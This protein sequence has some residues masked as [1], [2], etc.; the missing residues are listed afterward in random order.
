MHEP[1]LC[2]KVMLHGPLSISLS[3]TQRL[4]IRG[5]PSLD[6]G[7]LE[8]NHGQGVVRVHLVLKPVAFKLELA[9]HVA[10]LLPGD[11]DVADD[12]LAARAVCFQINGRLVRADAAELGHLGLAFLQ[13]VDPLEVAGVRQADLGLELHQFPGV[14]LDGLE[15]LAD[16]DGARLVL[17]AG[18]LLLD[19]IPE[20]A[21]LPGNAVLFLKRL[22][23]RN[24][25]HRLCPCICTMAAS[26][27]MVGFLLGKRGVGRPLPSRLC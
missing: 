18:I 3:S 12:L 2:V 9:L 22:G 21:D 14:Q 17:T 19:A 13:A 25:C 15:G 27:G 6:E 26:H 11:H 10:D 7:R 16:I 20:D 8:V 4:S 5:G 23:Q 1:A 24:L